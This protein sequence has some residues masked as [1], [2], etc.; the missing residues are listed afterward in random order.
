MPMHMFGFLWRF[1]ER[2]NG[3][4]AAQN[5]LGR[6]NILTFGSEVYSAAPKRKRFFETLSRIP[7][8]GTLNLIASAQ[9]LGQFS[10]LGTENEARDLVTL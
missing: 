10:A 2:P 7:R 8:A 5:S 4:R 3:A 1:Q 9:T 6:L